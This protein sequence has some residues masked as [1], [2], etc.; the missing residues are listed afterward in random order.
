MELVP[1]AEV[2]IVTSASQARIPE[3]ITAAGPAKDVT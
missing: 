3:L 1:K 2:S